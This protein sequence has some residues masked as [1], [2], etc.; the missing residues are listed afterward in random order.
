MKSSLA[1]CAALLLTSVAAKA[2]DAPTISLTVENDSFI[3]GSDRHYTN[4]LYGSWTGTAQTRDD[5]VTAI[6][7]A[8]MLS[9]APDARWREG[10]FLGQTMFTP[11]AL[12]LA[13]PP[14]DDRP[15]AGWLFAG[16]RL[17]RDNGD[18]LDKAEITLGLVGPASLGGDLHHAWHDMGLFGGVRPHGWGYQL[19]N[20]PGIILSQQRIWRLPLSE[21]WLQAE[22]L[23]QANVSLGNIF[24]YAEA[25]GMLRIGQG[26]SADWGPARIA[27]GLSGSD[28]Q[29]PDDFSWYLFAG[30]NG[31]LVG[32]NIFLDGNSLAQS[33]GVGHE[34]AVGDLNLGAALLWPQLRVSGSYVRR[35]NEFYSQRGN[36]EYLSISVS[37]AN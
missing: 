12:S 34:A 17:Y 36:D 32:R 19:R 28:F 14:A 30:V 16:A 24:T 5:A 22:V 35:S 13:I 11:Q 1:A 18:S 2:E 23:P 7:S 20:E 3:D 15:Y 31:R 25:G 4:G 9:G 27:P 10:Y 33:R 6:A 26:L 21:G 29:Q 37:F 8:L